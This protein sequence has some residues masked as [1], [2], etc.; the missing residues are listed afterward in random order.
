MTDDRII[1]TTSTTV[2]QML[3]VIQTLSLMSSADWC[4]ATS[5]PA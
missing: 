3:R 2:V 4:Q 1:Q 5:N